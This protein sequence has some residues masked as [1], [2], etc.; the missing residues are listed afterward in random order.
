MYVC[1]K[2]GFHFSG[3]QKKFITRPSQFNDD[4][5][6]RGLFI[7]FYGWVHFLKVFGWMSSVF[8]QCAR[9]D[10]GRR[11]GFGGSRVGHPT[12]CNLSKFISKATVSQ[13]FCLEFLYQ[14]LS[15]DSQHKDS[16][17]SSLL[18]LKKCRWSGISGGSKLFEILQSAVY[19][20][21]DRAV[22]CKKLRSNIFDSA[23]LSHQ[24]R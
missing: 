18:W 11:E 6:L 2:Y 22:K 19:R 13:H 12:T 15:N 20:I 21:R 3:R 16:G 1:R 14:W 17:E 24:L 23:V 4:I 5:Y 10:H 9:R 8:S 7:W